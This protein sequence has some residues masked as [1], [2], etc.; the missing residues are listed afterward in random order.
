LSI[1]NEFQTDILKDIDD[2]ISLLEENIVYIR[3]IKKAS[4]EISKLFWKRIDE[5]TNH[6]DSYYLMIDLSELNLTERSDPQERERGRQVLNSRKDKIKFISYIVPKNFFIRLVIKFV[7]NSI[8]SF[9]FSI[10]KSITA[11]LKSIINFEKK[12]QLI[13]I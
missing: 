11:G 12:N 4:P 2:R 10:D 5:V 6:L 8:E 3:S 1:N 13:I 7:M 9:P